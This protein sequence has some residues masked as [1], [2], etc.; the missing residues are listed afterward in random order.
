MISLYWQYP[1]L[2]IQPVG[3]KASVQITVSHTY[4]HCI[5]TITVQSYKLTEHAAFAQ[6]PNEEIFKSKLYRP[7][8][9][10]KLKLLSAERA[11]IA[12]A[13]FR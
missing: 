8:F 5:Y 2:K 6:P 9:C 13:I 7:D 11:I 3:I 10:S 1:L 4:N 12:D